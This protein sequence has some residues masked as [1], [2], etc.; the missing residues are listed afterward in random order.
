M[1]YALAG[2]VF[3]IGAAMLITGYTAPAREKKEKEVTARARIETDTFFAQ[4]DAKSA[5]AESA[6]DYANHITRTVPRSELPGAQLKPYF[7]SLEH[8]I[9]DEQFE[10]TARIMA[11]AQICSGWIIIAAGCI[12]L[13]IPGKETPLAVPG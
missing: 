6:S 12:I 7:Q 11:A 3:V 10:Q 1:K 5:A 13:A 9:E 2:L 4:L 8:K